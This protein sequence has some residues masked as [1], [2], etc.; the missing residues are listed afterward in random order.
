MTRKF[1]E[2]DLQ[3]KNAQIALTEFR[4]DLLNAFAT[5]PEGWANQLGLVIDG[6][7]GDTLFPITV[8]AEGF[9]RSTG[10]RM[11]ADADAKFIKVTP[12]DFERSVGDNLTKLR[13]TNFLGWQ[14]QPAIV[15][16]QAKQHPQKL[17]T[18]LLEAGGSTVSPLDG[19]NFFDTS[20]AFDPNKSKNEW[21]NLYTSVPLDSTGIETATKHFAKLK[22][23]AGDPLGLELTH[24]LV[25]P[26]D[27]WAAKKLLVQSWYPQAGATTDVAV[28]NLYRG[29]ATPIV[30][31]GLTSTDY[32]YGIASGFG[33][34]PWLVKQVDGGR[35]EVI[36]HD[37]SDALYKLEGKIGLTAILRSGAALGM[38]HCIVRFKKTA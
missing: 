8:V 38:P 7:V 6:D 16:R 18:A 11:F 13:K 32:W 21:K 31:K 36:T 27:E 23:P 34:W 19:K 9:A 30:A 3:S 29:V 1:I 35:L 33:M 37:E 17:I 28:D 15:T 22:D 20:R 25:H 10:R 24:V 26:D 4:A 5:A 14:Q 2:R 12:E